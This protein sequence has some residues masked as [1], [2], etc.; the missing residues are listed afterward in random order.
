M[1]LSDAEQLR[2]DVFFINGSV[3]KSAAA[4]W[5]KRTSQFEYKFLQCQRCF[6]LVFLAA[7]DLSVFVD[8]LLPSIDTNG[9][10][11]SL[12]FIEIFL[13]HHSLPLCPAL[14]H[15]PGSRSDGRDDCRA[16]TSW[17][18]NVGGRN[19]TKCSGWMTMKRSSSSL[20]ALSSQTKLL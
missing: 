16:E 12:F 7:C 17:I 13:C 8:W 3:S 19:W 2:W 5:R 6:F 9:R 20:T 1:W 10:N 11:F 14:S 18:M 4:V 15:K